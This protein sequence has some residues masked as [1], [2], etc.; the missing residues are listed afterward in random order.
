MDEAQA[1]A[2]NGIFFNDNFLF[3]CELKETYASFMC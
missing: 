2:C 3:P 1:L